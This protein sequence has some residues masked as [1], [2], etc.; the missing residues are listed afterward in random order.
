MLYEVITGVQRVP[1]R[2]PILPDGR[3]RVGQFRRDARI[4]TRIPQGSGGLAS[5]GEGP[6]RVVE[7]APLELRVGE[8]HQQAAAL[9]A[10]IAGERGERLGVGLDR[11]REVIGCVVQIAD[12]LMLLHPFPPNGKVC[13]SRISYNFV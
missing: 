8:P 9:D 10:G 13:M 4:L 3:Q 6:E 5:L 11:T 2:A 7:I 1:A 12:R